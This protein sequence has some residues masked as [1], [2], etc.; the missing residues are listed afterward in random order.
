MKFKRK[1]NEPQKKR[2]LSGETKLDSKTVEEKLINTF[3]E[4]LTHRY[5]KNNQPYVEAHVNMVYTYSDAD[6]E[7]GLPK[8]DNPEMG[9]TGG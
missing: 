3:H 1:Q 2:K 7:I 5:S 4:L 6:D 9:G 8:L